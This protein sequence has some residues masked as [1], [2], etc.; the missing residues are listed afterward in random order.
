[1]DVKKFWVTEFEDEES[2]K[3]A[4]ARIF[5]TF[6][7]NNQPL[8]V[9]AKT[10]YVQKDRLSLQALDSFLFENVYGEIYSMLHLLYQQFE[11]DDLYKFMIEELT[12]GDDG[13]DNLN[14]LN[15]MNAGG[16]IYPL[17]AYHTALERLSLALDSFE[18]FYEDGLVSKRSSINRRRLLR[19]AVHNFCEQRLQMDF[20]DSR[21][22]QSVMTDASGMSGMTPNYRLSVIS[23]S[24]QSN[25]SVSTI[26]RKDA[27][28]YL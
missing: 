10:E 8:Q 14:S 12:M 20:S 24:S 11:S 4:A 25:T 1:M 13:R 5:G 19:R 22:T 18:S 16:S 27:L 23:N 15:A 17:R 28:D 26:R 6:L 2:K 21:K 3:G 7:E 9:N